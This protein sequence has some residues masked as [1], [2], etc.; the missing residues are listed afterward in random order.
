ME[1]SPPLV[2]GQ[3]IVYLARKAGLLAYLTTVFSHAPAERDAW[4]CRTYNTGGESASHVP[5][6]NRIDQV[7]RASRPIGC[8]DLL[9]HLDELQYPDLP[10]ANHPKIS[11]RFLSLQ[12]ARPGS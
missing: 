11:A 2:V 10:C 8:L 3:P 5:V 6:P 9:S 12:R 4:F 1:S 7:V